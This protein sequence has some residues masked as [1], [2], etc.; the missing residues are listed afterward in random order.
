MLVH[1]PR[2]PMSFGKKGYKFSYMCIFFCKKCSGNGDTYWC[3]TTE[4]GD[5]ETFN[6]TCDVCE[7]AGTHTDGRDEFGECLF[8]TVVHLITSWEN[9]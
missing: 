6:E 5:L 7:G 9:T 2:T 8:Q 1:Y 4:D 3:G